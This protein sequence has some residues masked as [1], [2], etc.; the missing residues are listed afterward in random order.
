MEN[1]ENLGILEPASETLLGRLVVVR[2]ALLLL[3]IF[4]RNM[5]SL[6]LYSGISSPALRDIAVLKNLKLKA[7]IPRPNT[8][9]KVVGKIMSK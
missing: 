4:T 5:D 2:L 3:I 7:S 9:P 1:L 8:I 6:Q